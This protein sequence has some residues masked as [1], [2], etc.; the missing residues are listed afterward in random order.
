[1]PPTP[2]AVTER[3][4]EP[5]APPGRPAGGGRILA[6]GAV[7]L[8]V[9]MAAYAANLLSHPQA[10][11]LNWLDLRLYVAAGQ[12]ARHA[13][14]T[15]YRWQYQPGTPF[16]YPPFAAVLFEGLG[17]VPWDVL[18]WAVTAAS[19]LA[20]GLAVWLAF[21]GLGWTGKRRL[22]IAMAV[23][24]VAFWTE[25]VQRVLHWGQ[26]DLLLMV[27]VVWDLC[28][29]GHR[30]WQGA[31]IGLAA[32]VKLVPLIFIP[33]LLLTRRPRQ[34]A[35]ALATFVALAGVGFLALPAASAQW[36]FGGL[37]LHVGR[38]GFAGSVANQSLLGYLIRG[39]GS[40]AA[41]TPWWLAVSGLVAVN[42]LAAAARWH[43]GGRPVHGLLTCALTGLL[44]SPVSWDHHWVWLALAL[45]V[46]ADG[47]L[48]GRGLARWAGWACGAAAVALAAIAGAWPDGWPP[49]ARQPWGLIWT[50]PYTPGVT[51]PHP[52][53]HWHGAALLAGNLYL[54]AGLA[55]LTGLIMLAPRAPATGNRPAAV[56]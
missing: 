38:V 47:A 11:I 26:V 56:T 12:V 46:L 19:G 3:V 10:G 16:T 22:G 24:A 44:I 13:P 51:G 8:T 18:A 5:A 29:P 42:G 36:W 32:A 31:G 35:V 52:E 50:A 6:A 39:T 41:A 28:Q 1:M 37:W 45:A 14:A 33:Y 23:T 34:A 9:A 54:L 49:P 17:A 48:S 15:L 4:A 53:Y 55:L 25:P 7:A 27:L 21:G 43:H 20:L 40:I 2:P 30:R